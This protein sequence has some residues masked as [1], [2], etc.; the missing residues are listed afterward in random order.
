V[1][2]R[3]GRLAGEARRVLRAASVFGEVCW[4][5]GV[6]VLL[7]GAMGATMVGEWLASLI[8]QEV[9]AVRPTSGM[10]GERELKFRHA[11]LRE[12]AYA[13]LTDED[14][15]LGHR[16][17]GEWLEQH[18]EADPMVLAGHFE[19][20]GQGARAA[21]YYLRASE[22]AF[23]IL[24]LNA[25]L[26]RAGLGLACGPPEELRIALLGMRCEASSQDVKVFRA[27]MA[28]ADELM[29]SAPPGSIPWAQGMA[30]YFEGTMAFARIGDLPATIALLREVDPVLEAVGKMALVFV[31]GVCIID[32]FG[33]IADGT[34]LNERFFTIV[35]ST[36]EREPMTV[37]WWNVVIGVRAA[38]AHDD[39]G[40]ALAH[41]DAIQAIFDVI[42][43]QLIFLNMQL[44]RGVNLWYLGEFALAERILEAIA[45]ADEALG[46]V[47]S[48]RRFSLSWLR[49]DRGAF[50]EAR[51]LATQLSEYGQ[52]HH[53]PLEEGR[54]RWVLAEVLRRMGDF[55]GAERELQAALG[56]VIP[57]ERPGVLGTLS[58]LRLAQG[59]A[60]DA[61]AAAQDA[62]ACCTAMGGCGMFRGAFVRLAHAE[63]L[64]ATGAHDAARHAIAEARMR[65]FS[66]AGR[67]VDPARQQ[68]FL[69]NV[70]E[71]SRTL[72]L[73]RA[74]VGSDC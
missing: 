8:E 46:M 10:P 16:L 59:R 68:S 63:A 42:G 21:E 62:C 48:W 69:E 3:L 54:G 1:E 57:L 27:T 64:H 71:N 60:E 22:Q 55:E 72:A 7:G 38:Y 19:R 6:V 28:D 17:A 52:A 5:G 9:L 2:T 4:E 24:D 70:P 31:A 29:R 26:V 50:E 44:F 15:R 14:K 67:I 23:H 73:A 32:A 56:M 13:T 58:A 74:W 36:G 25:T 66:I 39:P 40:D 37:F 43:G 12:G 47:S 45:A 53:F 30:A 51:A 11:L 20:G 41:S 18:G 33:Q 34:A 49:A 61:L 35:R 65:L